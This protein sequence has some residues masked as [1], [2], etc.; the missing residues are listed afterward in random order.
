[1]NAHKGQI[2]QAI[3]DVFAVKVLEVNTVVRHRV[4]KK[5]GRKRISTVSPKT[6]KPMSNW[7]KVKLLPYLTL[8]ETNNVKEE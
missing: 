5:T 2:K 7:P 1:M 8:E 6:K 4:K 3:E